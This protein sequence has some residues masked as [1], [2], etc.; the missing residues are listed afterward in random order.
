[1]PRCLKHYGRQ[2]FKEPWFPS[3]RLKFQKFC[4]D[5]E[6]T[7]SCITGGVFEVD[8]VQ[9]S[10][11]YVHLLHEC[12][13]TKA[14]EDGR[15]VHADIIRSGMEPDVFLFNNLINMYIKCGNLE[16]ARQVFDKMTGR[17]SVSWNAIISGHAQHRNGEGS[18][19]LFTRMRRERINPTNFTFASLIN[20]CKQMDALDQA[21]QVNAY[22]VKIGFE[23]DIFVGS[24]FVDI[25]AKL[26]SMDYARKMFDQMPE[27]NVVS[28]NAMIAG[29]AQHEDIED[30]MDLFW[31]FL[32]TGMVPTEFTWATVLNA[33]SRAKALAPGKQAHSLILK[34]GIGENIFVGNALVDMYGKCKKVE[35]AR[36]S[37]DKM[38]KIDVV[39]WNSMIA[40]Y[41]QNE[42]E[43]EALELYRQMSQTGVGHNQTTM[44][45]ILKVCTNIRGLEQG[46]QVHAEAIKRGFGLDSFVGSALIDMYAKC[47][48]IFDARKLFDK[49]S[50]QNVVLWNAMIAGYTEGEDIEKH[51]EDALILFCQMRI[52]G[53]R[54]NEFTF[55]SVLRACTALQTTEWVEDAFEVFKRMCNQ[56]VVSGNAMIAGYAQHGQCEQALKL[57]CQ[58]QHRDLVSWNSMIAMH[59]QNRHNE[60]AL[61]LFHSMLQ[62]AIKPDEFTLVS[63]VSACANLASLEQSK[64]VHAHVIKYRLQSDVFVANVVV[65]MYAK[66]GSIEDSIKVFDKLSSRNVVSWTTMI[67]AYAHYGLGKEALLIFEQMQQR[68][69]KPDH[70]T[71]VGVL[72]ACSHAGLVDEGRH[73][74]DSMSRDHNIMPISDHYNCMV[75]LLS[76]AGYLDE[77]ENLIHRMTITPTALVWRTLLGA[78]RIHGNI[79]LGKRAAEYVLEFEPEDSAA[80]VLLANIHAESG[81]W[82]DVAKVRKLMKDRGVRKNPGQSWI[83]SKGSVHVFTMGD[84]LHPQTKEI[85]A[86]LESLTVQ[87]QE[88]GYVLH[89]NSLLRNTEHEH[90]DY[91]CH[92]SEKLAI[93]FGLINTP[94]GSYIRVIKNLR[95][96]NDCHTFIKFIS[97][98]VGRQIIVRDT[99]RFHHFKDGLCLCGDYW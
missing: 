75:D 14:L 61:K 64:G 53:M 23:S 65:D 57:F 70:V 62:D 34:H 17:D 67:S 46:R 7:L 43:V 98:M 26:G 82:D 13:K 49:T 89:T 72:S 20:A 40:G 73:Y 96:C 66:C 28:W 42:C 38:P 27:R 31:E 52:A 68:G 71:F 16:A 51:C 88:A 87:M 94:H 95:V 5:N 8:S 25:Y 35:D 90:R 69:I 15:S 44:A 2:I 9:K 1:M 92:H 10:A 86:K 97:K 29:C 41:A 21:L 4:I 91:F 81:G 22:V 30:A 80:Y 78:C 37:F 32:W 84:R 18:F 48:N 54:S 99:N 12:V 76:R 33:C 3:S 77:A 39:S 19:K 55:A 59:A 93:A 50:K 24:A 83:E 60:E 63:I 56:D 47:E 79:Q 74:F 6:R 36:F 11:F 45:S 58:M 85:Y